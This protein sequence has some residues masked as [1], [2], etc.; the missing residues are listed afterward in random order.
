MLYLEGVAFHT[1]PSSVKRFNLV[2]YT[3]WASNLMIALPWIKLISFAGYHLSQTPQ[4]YLKDVSTW[5]LTVNSL[6]FQLPF[7]GSVENLL[8]RFE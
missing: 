1:E 4:I 5:L 2:I 6:L 8:A 3:F 7:S